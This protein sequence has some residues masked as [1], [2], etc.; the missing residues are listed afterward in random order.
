MKSQIFQR[1]DSGKIGYEAVGGRYAAPS[2][3]HLNDSRVKWEDSKKWYFLNIN[4]PNKLAR[5]TL[6]IICIRSLFWVEIY[7]K[8]GDNVTAKK[9]FKDVKKKADRK[10]EAYNMLNNICRS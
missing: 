1:L 8:Q 4:I 3:S 6:G 9:Y 7:Q 5:L 2:L 10:D